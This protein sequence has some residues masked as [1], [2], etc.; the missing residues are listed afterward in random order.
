MLL[1]VFIESGTFHG[2]TTRWASR[3]FGT[4]HTI[5]RARSLYDLHSN[6]LKQTKGVNAHFG[7]SRDVLPIIVDGL[8]DERAVFWLD[9]HWSGGTTAG[10]QDECPLLGELGLK[11][12]KPKANRIIR[13]AGVA[14]AAVLCWVPAAFLTLLVLATQRVEIRI[15]DLVGG[16]WPSPYGIMIGEETVVQGEPLFI[17][18]VC[19]IFAPATVCALICCVLLW[20][21]WSKKGSPN[22]T[23][24]GIRQP[25]DGLPKPSM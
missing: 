19:L 21:R 3:H 6:E 16:S 7:D 5:E 23:S 18:L 11:E 8:K 10:A 14:V 15:L 17:P 20:K 2:G 24:E 13:V 4:V 25:A 22:H 12:M 1:N 9:G